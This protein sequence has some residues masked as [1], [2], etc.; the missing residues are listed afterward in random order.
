M[1]RT[2]YCYTGLTLISL[3]FSTFI[4]IWLTDHYILTINFYE[5]NGSIV[6]ADP[7]QAILLYQGIQRWIYFFSV[8]YLFVKLILITFILAAAL[9]LL[10]QQVPFR[11]IFQIVTMAEIV[12]II[13]AAVK[14]GT[15]LLM[16]PKGGLEEWHHFYPLSALSLWPDAP[17]DWSYLLQSLNVFEVSYWFLLAAGVKRVS[18]FG[19]DRALRLVMTSYLPALAIWIIIVTFCAVL[20]FPQM[21]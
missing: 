18:K 15:F 20:L 16:H 10:G 17:P 19:Y 14:L 11:D 1:K 2:R 5:K 12:F 3:L 21:N 7:Q 6:T 8:L 4:L 13:S 9:Y